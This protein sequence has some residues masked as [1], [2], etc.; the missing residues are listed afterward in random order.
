MNPARLP[1]NCTIH[2]ILRPSRGSAAQNGEGDERRRNRKAFQ[3]FPMLVMPHSK[4]LGKRCAAA[5]API[6]VRAASM[7]RMAGGGGWSWI[8]PKG[9][10]R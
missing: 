5:C 3:H 9:H 6:P 1:T 7:R 10:K 8:R 4:P 2:G